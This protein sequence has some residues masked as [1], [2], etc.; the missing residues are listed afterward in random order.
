MRVLASIMAHP[1]V[2]CMHAGGVV[3]HLPALEVLTVECSAVE[4]PIRSDT[5]RCIELAGC[6]GHCMAV[7]LGLSPC[8]ASS[9][10]LS[11]DASPSAGVWPCAFQR[12][13]QCLLQSA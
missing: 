11:P 2:C 10:G 4:R 3:H 6:D 1:E 8:A 5:L 9:A 7:R 13:K 12:R